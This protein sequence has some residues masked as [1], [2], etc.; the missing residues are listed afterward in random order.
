M[1]ALKGEEVTVP[2][3]SL[4]PWRS[5][6]VPVEPSRLH[7]PGPEGVGGMGEIKGMPLQALGPCLYEGCALFKVT[8]RDK[9]GVPVKG[10]CTFRYLAECAEASAG[11]VQALTVMI[12][13]ALGETPETMTALGLRALRGA[14]G[15]GSGP[16]T[17]SK[18]GS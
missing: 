11:A 1:A 13:K 4:C 10:L 16:G 5:P 15:G 7:V 2:E 18:K 14:K 8:E 3:A 6:V 9:N 12:S 17:P